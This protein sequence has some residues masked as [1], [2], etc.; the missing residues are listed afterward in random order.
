MEKVKIHFRMAINGEKDTIFDTEAN[1]IGSK[2]FFTD[3]ENFRYIV[4]YSESVV[5]I[6]RIGLTTMKLILKKG[7]PSEG[8]FKTQGLSFPFTVMTRY[9]LLKKQ[10]LSLSYDMLDNESVVTHHEMN[11][12]WILHG[13]NGKND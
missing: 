1:H 11:L 7:E 6:E 13:R 3:N 9:I 8:F 12:K 4:E 5:R 2:L 10:E